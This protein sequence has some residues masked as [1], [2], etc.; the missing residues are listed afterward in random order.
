MDLQGVSGEQ[1]KRIAV[2]HSYIC[3]ENLSQ[4][5]SACIYMYAFS[6][7]PIQ[8]VLIIWQ[9]EIIFPPRSF[10]SWQLLLAIF[11]LE[12]KFNRWNTGSGMLLS[13]K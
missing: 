3:K 1:L 2:E 9:N 8:L 13:G 10:V 6:S 4:N 5:S 7:D 12:N 11:F